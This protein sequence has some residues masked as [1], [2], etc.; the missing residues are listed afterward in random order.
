[1]IASPNDFT[2]AVR[3]WVMSADVANF[4]STIEEHAVS[5][6]AFGYV[7]LKGVYRKEDIQRIALTFDKKFMQDLEDGKVQSRDY[8]RFA[9]KLP[10]SAEYEPILNNPYIHELMEHILGEDYVLFGFSSHSSLPGSSHQFMHVDSM[11]SLNTNTFVHNEPQ[12]VFLHIPLIDMNE[13]HGATE[14]WP[15]TL[16]SGKLQPGPGQIK[17]MRWVKNNTAKCEETRAQGDVILRM[18]NCVHAGGAN[19]SGVR[20]HMITLVFARRNYFVTDNGG[21]IPGGSYDGPGMPRLPYR[22]ATHAP[23]E[24]VRHGDRYTKQVLGGP[25]SLTKGLGS[26]IQ[27][28]Q[29]AVV[30]NAILRGVVDEIAA[31]PAEILASANWTANLAE[32]VLP[33]ARAA[34]GGGAFVLHSVTLNDKKRPAGCDDPKFA[35]YA[36]EHVFNNADRLIRVH[37]PLEDSETWVCACPGNK[38]LSMKLMVG[39]PD[40]RDRYRVNF[41]SEKGM[42][43]ITTGG[44]VYSRV[45]EVPTVELTFVRP[46]FIPSYEDRYRITDVFALSLPKSLGRV[47][48]YDSIY[49]TQPR[50]KDFSFDRLMYVNYVFVNFIANLAYDS[51]RRA[52]ALGLL[53]L[54]AS[55]PLLPFLVCAFAIRSR[56]HPVSH[57]LSLY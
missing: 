10:I 13:G 6:A 54:T 25:L 17:T 32:Q 15:I 16:F 22:I 30:K 26:Q 2:L 38:T 5:V 11:D 21:M 19:R 34:F 1:V 57:M 37:V 27:F 52:T 24:S 50:Y 12:V 39:D 46:D 49:V 20:R 35:A 33:A 14:V 9:C 45:T 53:A 41:A 18:D 31:R 47:L 40:L 29:Y 3:G 36:G 44:L 48:R 51:P 55:L 28:S 8:R 56:K 4:R 43:L 7:A 42:A 23:V